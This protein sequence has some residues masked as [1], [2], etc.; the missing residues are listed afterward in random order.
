[1]VV[2]ACA[3]YVFVNP[4]REFVTVNDPSGRAEI[5]IM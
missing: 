1:L 4:F 3:A 2:R 5:L